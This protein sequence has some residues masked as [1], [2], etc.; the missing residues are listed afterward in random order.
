MTTY[1]YYFSDT[2][3]G[4]MLGQLPLEGVTLQ[5]ALSA[6]GSF[7][8]TVNLAD[9]RLR[10]NVD[11]AGITQPGRASYWV[12]RDGAL[13]SGGVLWDREYDSASRSLS[14]TGATFDSYADHRINRA[15]LLYTD[16]DLCTVIIGL[17]GALQSSVG[18][19]INMVLP[20]V[21]SVLS[22][23]HT[24]VE[25]DPG[26]QS[27]FGSMIQQLSQGSP[28]VDYYVHTFYDTDMS[29]GKRL[30]LGSPYVGSPAA[31]TGLVFRRPGGI[32]DYKWPE[33]GSQSPN[34][35]YAQG[36]GS[37]AD[38]LQ[39]QYVD[40]SVLAAGNPLLEETVAFKDVFTQGKLDT[41]INA[42]G[43]A[44][45]RGVTTPTLNLRPDDPL[46]PPG[47]YEVGDP[48][49]VVIEPDERFVNG[50]DALM[51][52]TSISVNPPDVGQ[53]EAVSI[54]LGEAMS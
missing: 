51:R 15:L 44:K 48:C 17:W 52:I 36:A 11:V 20:T 14:L 41:L 31:H 39:S 25:Y 19:D 12:D 16:L 4:A 40:A 30:V 9:E 45:S 54:T 13:I 34:S 21:G 37:G 26:Q 8:A 2:L 24:T 29:F 46:N 35:V 50:L 5:R 10:Q 1:T 28:G 23:Q 38:M 18:G 42:Y 49:R 43:K 6:V 27:T 33:Y 47:S 53:T 7:S 3:T 32:Q 22:G